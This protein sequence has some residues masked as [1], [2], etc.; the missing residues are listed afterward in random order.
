MKLA[1]YDN[2]RRALG[3]C[4]KV[5]EVK[6][7]RDKA[8]AMEAYARQAKDMSLSRYATEIRLRA[9]R[10]LGELMEAQRVAMVRA[11]VG[12]P[13][14]GVDRTPLKKA[15][16]D[17]ELAK[18]ARKAAV[19]PE[20]AYE[21]KIAR[22]IDL[23]EKAASVMGK[24]AHVKSE[25]TGEVEWYTPGAILELVRRVLGDI[26]LDPASSEVAQKKVLATR[27]YTVDDD[28]LKRD[29]CGRIWL[30][31]PYA[32]P[33]I[34]NFMVKMVEQVSS[35]NVTQ[36]I[37]LTHNYTDTD[38]FHAGVEVCAALCF[39]R[40]RI[41]FYDSEGTVAAPTQGQAFFYFGNQVAEFRNVFSDIGFV[42]TP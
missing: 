41:K 7:I 28:G 18:R 20:A 34:A 35:G 39:T 42:V 12:R 3:E 27:F 30:N 23:A 14:K 31:P 40:G 10:R 24:A 17:K 19:M 29:W 4:H 37:M 21:K 15:G 26:D 8:V 32:Q 36:A 33:H 22:Q 16:I 13:K 25:F 38:W 6:K 2:A 1:R 11:G 9:E 5:D